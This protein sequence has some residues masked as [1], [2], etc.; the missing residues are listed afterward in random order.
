[1]YIFIVSLPPLENQFIMWY[2]IYILLNF[3]R[4]KQYGKLF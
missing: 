2:N 4:G 1:L 3:E